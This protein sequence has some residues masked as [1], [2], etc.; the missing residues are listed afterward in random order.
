MTLMISPEEFEV[1]KLSYQVAACSLLFNLIPAV[2]IGWVLAR[3]EFWGKSLFE[4]FI[5]LPLV[6]PPVIPGY[7]LLILFGNEGFIGRYLAPLG[8]SFSFNWKGAVLAS[9]VMGFPLMVQSVRLAFEMVDQRLEMVAQTLGASKWRTFFQ[10]T[11]PL[12]WGGI[13]IGAI[14]CFCRSLGEFGATITFVGNIAGE[15]RTLPLAIYSLLQQP[16]SETAI[17]RLMALSIA[18]A[19][20]ALWL[21]QWYARHQ[22]RRMAR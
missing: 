3:K 2:T 15:T 5:F 8:I 17:N 11:L 6:L 10:V 7:L 12:A 20:T 16:N 14:L 4:T 9:A 1:L 19:F 18:V 21:S 13:V 22:K